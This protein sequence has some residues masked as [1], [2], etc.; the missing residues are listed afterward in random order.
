MTQTLSEALRTATKEAHVAAERSGIMRQLLRGTIS[1]PAY[2]DLLRNLAEIYRA[3][4]RARDAHCDL[5]ALAPFD[6][7]VL[8]RFDRLEADIDALSTDDRVHPLRPTTIEY[9]ARLDEIERDSP[10]LLLSHAYVRYLGDLSGGQIL[11]GIVAK[12]FSLQG[13]HGT[14]FYAFPEIQD[15]TAYK[16]DVRDAINAAAGSIISCDDVVREAQA[17]FALHERIFQELE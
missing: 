15:M 11:A 9:V 10:N 3:L 12:T 1:Q 8:R 13:E 2:V 5:A 17:G 7:R 6:L 14:S 4:E 16:R